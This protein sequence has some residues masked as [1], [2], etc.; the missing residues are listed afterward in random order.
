MTTL[1]ALTGTNKQIEWAE[2]LRA[3]LDHDIDD[4]LAGKTRTQTNRNKAA[5]FAAALAPILRRIALTQTDAAWWIDNRLTDEACKGGPGWAYA[6]QKLMTP[7]DR[8][9]FRTAATAA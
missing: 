6:A 9:E 7:A 4:Y 2:D 8:D 5:T 1:P 3:Q